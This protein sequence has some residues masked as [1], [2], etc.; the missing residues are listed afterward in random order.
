MLRR[1]AGDDSTLGHASVA[2]QTEVWG[3]ALNL[4][5]RSPLFTALA[6][7]LPASPVMGNF[8]GTTVGF[9]FLFSSAYAAFALFASFAR[10]VNVS[11]AHQGRARLWTSFIFWRLRLHLS[12]RARLRPHNTASSRW[13]QGSLE[14]VTMMCKA[15]IL[16]QKRQRPSL[17]TVR[18]C[19][20]WVYVSGR[21]AARFAVEKRH[22]FPPGRPWGNCEG[23][24]SL[25]SVM[26][27]DHASVR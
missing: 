6:A 4:H 1:G 8:A 24:P 23:Q 16:P 11:H 25:A 27:R 21:S 2:E 5:R 15:L 14:S 13:L 17:D 18:P 9:S 20:A 7:Q 3:I 22:S 12:S 19:F 10:L 26:L